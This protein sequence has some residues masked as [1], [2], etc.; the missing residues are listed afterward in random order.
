[1]GNTWG[2]QTTRKFPSKWTRY[3]GNFSISGSDRWVSDQW[4]RV[5]E[6]ADRPTVCSFPQVD[7]GD[8]KCTHRCT[9]DGMHGC[10]A[11]PRDRRPY[12]DAV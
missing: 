3:R 7:F 10:D 12:R 5:V 8:V 4:M 2:S 9:E 1:M 11:D 6:V